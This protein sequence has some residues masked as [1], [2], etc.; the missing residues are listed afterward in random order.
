ML[1][2]EKVQEETTKKRKAIET[3][4]DYKFRSIERQSCQ[5]SVMFLIPLFQKIRHSNYSWA[6]ICVPNL[7]CQR[8]FYV[9]FF[10]IA[11]IL[12]SFA[13]E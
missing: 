5:P 6:Q 13:L 4:R 1:G 8:K 10:L 2:D 3:V 11:E 7:T 9:F 12:Q